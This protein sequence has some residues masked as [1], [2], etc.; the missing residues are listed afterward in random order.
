[1][2][3]R[4][5]SHKNLLESEWVSEKT[6][7]VGINL[8]AS[9]R[10]ESKAWPLEYIAQLCDML[11]VKNIRV[12]LTG[13]K[14]DKLLAR[15]LLQM[16]KAK[17]ANFTGKTNILQLALLIKRCQVYI[18]PDSAPMHVAAAT[19][20]PFLAL[21]GPTDPVRHLPPSQRSKVLCKEH[22]CMPCYSAHCPIGSH[23]C[24]R[25]INPEEVLEAVETL[26]GKDLS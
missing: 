10:W 8:A 19:Q 21:F 22:T 9:K 14:E 16:T 1:M 5:T 6:I 23:A 26:L 15:R 3:D 24:M 12:A 17:P 2:H 25:D 18:T 4:C 13:T 20:T 7:L 11:A